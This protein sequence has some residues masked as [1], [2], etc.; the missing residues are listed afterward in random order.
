MFKL[1]RFI[2]STLVFIGVT[3]LAGCGSS[4]QEGPNYYQLPFNTTTSS[5]QSDQIGRSLPVVWIE[6]IILSSQLASRNIAFQ[7]SDVN[8]TLAQNHLWASAL[9]EQLSVAFETDL[10]AI[11]SGFFITRQG[12]SQADYRVQI[13]VLEFHPRFD[14]KVV[15]SGRF[16]IT[17]KSGKT[18]TQ[19]FKSET[20][21]TK[22]GYEESV[23]QLAV[24][25]QKEIELI[26]Q[27]IREIN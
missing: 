21:L 24:L 22:D 10:N 27:K 19:A 26:A 14:G 9:E 1:T 11:L 25:W 17:S 7:T 8:Y 13:S 5:A 15:M 18:I 4:A 12:N 2:Q 6:P 23:R 20:L 3:F 16:N